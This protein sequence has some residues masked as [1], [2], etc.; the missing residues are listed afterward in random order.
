MST[1]SPEALLSFSL[2]PFQIFLQLISVF[3]QQ[4]NIISNLQLIKLVAMYGDSCTIL[5][6]IVSIALSRNEMKVVYRI[7]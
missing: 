4:S 1:V 2:E 5:L 7:S 3:L 6:Y